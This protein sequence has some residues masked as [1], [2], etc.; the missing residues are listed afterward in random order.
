MGWY[1]TVIFKLI[2]AI[3]PL[4]KTSKQELPQ[5]SFLGYVEGQ[6]VTPKG[7]ILVL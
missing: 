4:E 7:L 2:M 5:E 6:N 1:I 3:F